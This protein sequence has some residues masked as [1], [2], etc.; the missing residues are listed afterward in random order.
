MSLEEEK[1]II[2]PKTPLVLEGW[3]KLLEDRKKI[4][5]E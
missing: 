5:L 2:I 4:T 3:I 1:P